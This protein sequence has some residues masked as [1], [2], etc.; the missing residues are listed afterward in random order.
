MRC[1][2]LLLLGWKICPE[3]NVNQELFEFD[4]TSV[5][6]FHY[7]IDFIWLDELALLGEVRQR[8]LTMVLL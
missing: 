1:V 4:L 7:L 6:A 8:S 2:C 5:D 3:R